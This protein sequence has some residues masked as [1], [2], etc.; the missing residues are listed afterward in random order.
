M[1]R[2]LL[3]IAFG[4]GIEEQNLVHFELKPLE[5]RSISGE[6]SM[7]LHISLYRKS[8][9]LVSGCMYPK[10]LESESA[11]VLFLPMIHFV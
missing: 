8:L 10:S 5:K 3:F 9:S 4:L 7:S 2:A 11:M 1:L 6:Y